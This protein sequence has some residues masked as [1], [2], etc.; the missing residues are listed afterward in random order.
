MQNKCKILSKLVSSLYACSSYKDVVVSCL[1]HIIVYALLSIFY[2]YPST[3]QK[4]KVFFEREKV[5]GY[6]S[7]C[8]HI[9]MWHSDVSVP[10]LFSNPM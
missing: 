6:L 7:R 4:I 5:V 2:F 1:S 10:L 9:E 3:R 8:I